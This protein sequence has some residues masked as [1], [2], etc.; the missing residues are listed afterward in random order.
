MPR[1]D[2]SPAAERLRRRSRLA[3]LA[4][5]LV[6]IAI[7]LLVLASW[8]LGEAPAAALDR[9]GRP[10]APATILLA[11]AMAV[12]LAPAAALCLSLLAA[13]RCFA[14][15]ADGDWF[16]PG[17]PRALATCGRWLLVSGVASLLA[18]TLVGLALTWDAPAGA[19]TL[20]LDVSSAALTACLFGALMLV[21]GGAWESA[22]AIAAENEQFV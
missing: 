13:G 9:L 4:C 11:T 6:A 12:S 2:A 22:R 7:P 16:G 15:F 17:Q 14:G 20:V 10:D 5:R 19:R 8:L 1:A 3:A 18:P 21:L